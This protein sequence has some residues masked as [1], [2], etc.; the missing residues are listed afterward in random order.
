MYR[1]RASVGAG[2]MTEEEVRRALRSRLASRGS[3]PTPKR[4]GDLH[5]FLAYRLANWEAV[6]PRELRR[7]GRVT[8]FEWGSLGFDHR[9]GNWIEQRPVMNRA[10]LERFR[11]A[12]AEQPVDC[13]VGY[14][15][16]HAV[17]PEMVGTMA[18]AGTAVFNFC[19][20]DKLRFRGPRVGGWRTGPAAIARCVDLN[21]T[22]APSS[23]LRYRV[24]GS[25][26]LF[27]PEGA[28]PEV[29]RPYEGDFEFDVSFVGKRYGWRP[30]FLSKLERA[31]IRVEAFGSGWPNGPLDDAE[32]VRLYSR[33]RI[34]LG[35]GGI[36]YSRRLL[37]LKGRDFE[38]PMSGGL[39]LTQ[40]NPELSLVYDVGREIVTY[41]DEADCAE[42][43]RCLLNTPREAAEIRARGRSRALRDHTWEARFAK[44]F[45]LAGLLA[46]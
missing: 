1:L 14:L 21:L 41:Q 40:E 5:V 20:D 38:V 24:E 27:W 15:S 26:A 13:V 33:S 2:S 12:H 4:R 36:G 7:F 42:K 28:S 16:G 30:A 32:M 44:L 19:W 35:F 46:E 10:M 22:N 39:Y 6:L 45:E 31:G 11:S 37:C 29:H 9:V 8:E 34:N 23:V 17:S 43:I 18:R 3:A 25:L